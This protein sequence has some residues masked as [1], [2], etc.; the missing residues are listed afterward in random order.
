MGHC[1]V[2]NDTRVASIYT[3]RGYNPQNPLARPNAP[4]SC[5]RSV[6]TTPLAAM[7][8]CEG[9]ASDST[10]AHV[11]RA[12]DRVERGASAQTPHAATKFSNVCRTRRPKSPTTSCGARSTRWQCT[13]RRAGATC[14]LR[15]KAVRAVG[16]S[17]ERTGMM[18]NL[19]F[20]ALCVHSQ[21]HI[22]T[23]VT[24]SKP[25]PPFSLDPTWPARAWLME[26]YTAQHAR[27]REGKG[28]AK[29]LGDLA[30]AAPPS[31]SGVSG[32]KMEATEV[33]CD[34]A[35][36]ARSALAGNRR[37]H[38]QCRRVQRYFPPH[39]PNRCPSMPPRPWLHPWPHGSNA[40][41]AAVA[42]SLGAGQP[43]TNQPCW[44]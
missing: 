42:P 39:A 28:F 23:T 26:V 5:G 4:A 33:W 14:S 15:R 36:V 11:L 29:A 8:R 7:S 22:R 24:S 1:G 2:S 3:R 41:L 35:F 31:G 20:F 13:S 12:P 9:A 18:H 40:M 16:R 38:S 43:P 34:H 25:S 27:W 32:L 6:G 21:P 44:S 17:S 19:M 30:V 10:V 37:P